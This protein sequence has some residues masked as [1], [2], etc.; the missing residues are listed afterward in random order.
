MQQKIQIIGWLGR[1]PEVR[2]TPKGLAVA[3]FPVSTERKYRDSEGKRVK[4]IVWFSVQVWGAPGESCG[5]YL[6]KG[7]LVMVYGRLIPDPKTCGPKVWRSE[8]G[9]AKANFEINAATVMFLPPVMTQ[10]GIPVESADDD[11]YAETE[12]AKSRS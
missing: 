12:L 10:Y 5:R 3:N 9:Q 8:D 1:D 2:Y 11:P 7:H 6:K 4:E